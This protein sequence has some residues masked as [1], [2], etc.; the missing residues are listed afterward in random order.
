MTSDDVMSAI[1]HVTIDKRITLGQD[2]HCGSRTYFAYRSTAA[3]AY[4]STTA[5][6]RST[7]AAV[8]RSTAAAYRSTAAAAYRSTAAAYRS[9][10]A[11]YWSTA[12]AA[13]RGHQLKKVP[14]NSNAGQRKQRHSSFSVVSRC[15]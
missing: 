3:A 9:T 13:Y 10:A 6:Y 15:S 12:A 4:R 1:D 5:A 8:Y 7:A 2:R 14:V 11:A